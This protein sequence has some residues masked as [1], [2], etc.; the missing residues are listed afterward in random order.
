MTRLGAEAWFV[1]AAIW[2]SVMLPSAAF[3]Y[4]AGDAG[5]V[6]KTAHL[7]RPL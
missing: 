1:A 3:G 2:L 5:A 6:H 4:W 7:I